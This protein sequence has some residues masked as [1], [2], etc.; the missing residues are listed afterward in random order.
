MLFFSPE[1]TFASGSAC[2]IPAEGGRLCPG[3][4]FHRAREAIPAA[5][6]FPKKR[7]GMT[8]FVIP[9]LLRSLH[10]NEN[11]VEIFIATFDELRSFQPFGAAW[12]PGGKI[13]FPAASI[14]ERPVR[15]PAVSHR[16]HQRSVFIR[17]T[18]AC[19]NTT[20][21]NQ[22]TKTPAN[23]RLDTS[24]HNKLFLPPVLRLSSL[25]PGSSGPAVVQKSTQ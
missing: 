21:H 19:L 23:A 20:G 8:V 15:S 12:Q 11:F 17:G 2:F 10:E 1:R 3:L 24:E 16:D 25:H 9:H 5:K 7:G 6:K 22:T 14:L 13:L 18:S 4:R